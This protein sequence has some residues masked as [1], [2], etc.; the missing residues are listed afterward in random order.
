MWR[1]ILY[2]VL[3]AWCTDD[4][5]GYT[6]RHLYERC[7]EEHLNLK[8]KQQSEVKDHIR[9][10]SCCKQADI[11]YRDFSILRRCQ[12]E[13][14]AKLFEAFLIKRMRPS[15]N[16]QLFAQGASKILHIWK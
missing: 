11:S 5:I 1:Q 13:V 7:D 16:K 8:K 14:H 12:S 2:I 6:A 3:N 4:Y 15:L 9:N 10:C